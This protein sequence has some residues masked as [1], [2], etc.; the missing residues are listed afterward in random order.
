VLA[1]T[2]KKYKR[3]TSL[4]RNT[5]HETYKCSEIQRPIFLSSCFT[6]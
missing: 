3:S 1:L 5:Y 2:E 6:N 4:F